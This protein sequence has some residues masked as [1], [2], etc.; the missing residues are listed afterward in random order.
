MRRGQLLT[1]DAML[2]L[3]LVV[4]ILATVTNTSSAL[5]E[6]ISS[7]IE[8]QERANI[9]ENM[10]DVLTKSPGEPPNWYL[11]PSSV[12]VVGLRSSD[13]TYALNYRK[14]MALNSSI[15]ELV[16]ALTNL[17]QGKDFMI[18]TFVSKYK[19]G[20]EGRFP[21]VYLSN[22]TFKSPVNDKQGVNFD[23]VK[24]GTNG[25][26]GISYIKLKL[27]NG[28]EY[29]NSG[30]CD[31]VNGKSST[32]NTKNTGVYYV[33]VIITDTVNLTAKRGNGYLPPSP[34][35]IPAGSV[36]ELYLNQTSAFNLQ[37]NGCPNSVN[38]V[39]ISGKGNIKVTVSAYDNSIP[40]LIA[41]YTSAPVFESLGN[42][43]YAFAVIN[44]TVVT[45]QGVINASMNRSP[46]IEVGKRT[47][48]I[49]KFEY[50]LSASPSAQ[51]PMIYGTLRNPLPG[52]AYLKVMVPNSTG[53]MSFVAI[54][55]IET[56][57]LLIHKDNSNEP[58][59][60]I[61]VY[62]NTTVQYSGNAT[63]VSIPL[64]AL[65]GSPGSGDTIG[66]W[67]YSLSNSWNRNSVTIEC[68]PDLRWVLEPRL[69]A[70]IIKLWVWDDS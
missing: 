22:V 44:G 38:S 68:V 36:I 16:G 49:E 52:G 29:I 55:G 56:R 40:K 28:S 10:L 5:K 42:P 26:F 13:K 67:F 47:G 21:R 69:E 32:I 1:L 24:S 6:E 23:I 54:S 4:F 20:I 61:L 33:K 62:D 46:W 59:T 57:G 43:T 48:I 12:K 17:S 50:N 31:L 35:E 18:E 30:V 51:I 64:N 41:N 65:F 7:M 66:L 9:A 15:D 3:I 39:T 8:W 19:V 60:G 53:N 25:G 14:L 27:L 2:S 37:V 45:D 70:A 63:S 34:K 58:V 11:D